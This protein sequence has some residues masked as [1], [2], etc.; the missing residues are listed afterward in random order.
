[1]LR[2]T[3]GIAAATEILVAVVEHKSRD[4][5]D[6]DEGQAEPDGGDM[7]FQQMEATGVLHDALVGVLTL[8]ALGIPHDENLKLKMYTLLGSQT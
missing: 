8:G 7:D 1:M 2:R 4:E 6:G 5:D 3:R